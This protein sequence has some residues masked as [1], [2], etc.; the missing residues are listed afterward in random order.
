MCSVII[1]HCNRSLLHFFK[2]QSKHAIFKTRFYKLMSHMN[3]SRTS[4]TVIINIVNGYTCHSNFINSFVTTTRISINKS[5]ASTL[6]L[7]KCNSCISKSSVYCLLW[8]DV[9]I[10]IWR[11]TWLYELSH[12]HSNNKN[13]VP[14]NLWSRISASITLGAS[15]NVPCE[16]RGICGRRYFSILATHFYC[17]NQ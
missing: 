4:C 1:F 15:Y 17:C 2:P 11:I 14:N 6:N 8:H 7:I 3:S 9:I 16:S 10:W 13:S 5:Y 12:S